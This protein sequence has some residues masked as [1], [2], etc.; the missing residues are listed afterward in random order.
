MVGSFLLYKFHSLFFSF[1]ILISSVVK[2][3]EKVVAFS[4]KLVLLFPHQTLAEE[5]ALC[6]F[7]K[8][9]KFFL[10]MVIFS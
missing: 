5:V 2:V 4:S 6:V 7:K 3:L 10:E 8:K 1:E 9:R